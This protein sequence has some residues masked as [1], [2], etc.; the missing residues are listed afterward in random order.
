MLKNYSALQN[1]PGLNKSP[2]V[3][4]DPAVLQKLVE[5]LK[6]TLPATKVDDTSTSMT[7]KEKEESLKKVPLTTSCKAPLVAEAATAPVDSQCS[8][9]TITTVRSVVKSKPITSHMTR[10]LLLP[11]NK[12]NLMQT[13]NT[14]KMAVASSVGKTVGSKSPKSVAVEISKVKLSGAAISA[15]SGKVSKPPP[16][17]EMDTSEPTAVQS[18]VSCA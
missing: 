17:Q 14:S 4:G 2:S 16:S 12:T 5:S 10:S 13:R 6:Q 11:G 8:V 3:V 15:A 7:K 9:G 18:L 1:I